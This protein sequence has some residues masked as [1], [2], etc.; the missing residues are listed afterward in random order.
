MKIKNIPKYIVALILGISISVASSSAFAYIYNPTIS[1]GG[2]G[3]GTVTQVSTAG[4]VSGGPITS[5]GT[6]QLVNDNAT[7]GNSKYYG[8]DASG[9]KGFFNVS[10]GAPGG[11]N[12]QLQY[13]N[14][15]VFGGITGAVTDGT[16]VSLTNAHLL[17]PTINGAGVGLATLAYPNTSSSATITF[18]TVTGT[19]ATLAGTEALTNKSVNGVTLTTGGGT[20]TFLN[21]NGT[22]TTP[23]GDGTGLIGSTLGVISNTTPGATTETWLGQATKGTASTDHT[24]FLGTDTGTDAT[25]AFYS[26]ALGANALTEATNASNSIAIGGSAGYQSPTIA[27]SII[28]GSNAAYQDTVDNTGMGNNSSILIGNYTNTGGFQNSIVMGNNTAN[29]AE[30]QFLLTNDEA[31]PITQ[32]NMRGINMTMPDAGTVYDVGDVLSIASVDGTDD[33]TLDWAASAGGSQNLQ[34]VTDIGNTTTND[35]IVTNGSQT[36]A[37]IGTEVPGVG[38]QG[39]ARFYSGNNDHVSIITPDSIGFRNTSDDGGS[40]LQSNGSPDGT[41]YTSVLPNSAG[42]VLAVSVNG[43]LAD[44]TGNITMDIGGPSIPLAGTESGEL[45]TGNLQFEDSTAHNLFMN[46]SAESATGTIGFDFDGTPLLN[47]LK[48]GANT[49]LLIQTDN[50]NISSDNPTFRGL[51]G[52]ADY[53]SLITDLDYVQKIYVDTAVAGAAQTLQ[54]VTDLGSFTTNGMQV[55]RSSDSANIISLLGGSYGEI[56]VNDPDASTTVHITGGGITFDTTGGNASIDNS[57]ATMARTLALP[58]GSGTLPLTVNGL[59]ADST[60]NITLTAFQDLQGVTDVGN[61]TTNAIF[62]DVPIIGLYNTAFTTNQANTTYAEITTSD[63][64]FGYFR[65]V[66]TID[67]SFVKQDSTGLRSSAGSVIDM[68][69]DANSI[70]ITAG[71]PSLGGRGLSGAGDYSANITD[72]DYVQKTYVDS[73]IGNDL[74]S[75]TDIGATTTNPIIINDGGG[76][77][78]TLAVDSIMFNGDD[79]SI[80][81]SSGGSEITLGGDGSFSMFSGGTANI[82]LG[83][84]AGITFSMSD[85]LLI[86]GDEG[87]V[88][89]VLKSQGPGA[90]PIWE[91]IPTLT[92]GTY[93]PTLTNVTNITSTTAQNATYTRMGSTVTVYGSF[94]VTTTLAVA[95][96]VDISLPVASNLAAATDLNGMGQAGSAIA[97]NAVVSGNST[98]DRAS[99]NFIGLAVSGAGRIYYSFSYTVI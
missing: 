9:T 3:S 85:S 17:S 96:Q 19:L 75:V 35:I 59:T 45:I 98:N 77:S 87:A 79:A 55:K 13:N 67:D 37:A 16:A 15:G 93:T 56:Q 18:P 99:I 14:N 4:S 43:I 61:T 48:S 28:I 78:T 73:L 83:S 92:N 40:I 94:D 65:V 52:G 90:A 46:N 5:S 89:A 82:M 54:E 31:H 7:P 97:A 62:S 91:S 10:I 2:G 76:N 49:S 50:V 70:K 20:T 33:Y 72:L 64:G 12:T 95:S 88:G 42:N 68:L 51:A 26:I 21:A 47:L 22:Y 8:T 84:N 58:D 81:H 11:L 38:T 34:Q 30:G 27:N 69:G 44:N 32:F 80:S 86:N 60:G 25:N 57:N 66:S 24:L 36:M 63:D 1:G 53:S 29:T 71:D 74:Q 41:A 23:S 39:Y 6:V